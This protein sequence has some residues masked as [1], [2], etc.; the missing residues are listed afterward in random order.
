MFLQYVICKIAISELLSLLFLLVSLSQEYRGAGTTDGTFRNHQLFVCQQDCGVFVPI[1]RIKKRWPRL[2]H[3]QETL[4]KDTGYSRSWLCSE[5][6]W[7]L[8]C[9]SE[10]SF[11]HGWRGEGGACFVLW[12][13]PWCQDR[14]CGNWICKKKKNASLYFNHFRFVFVGCSLHLFF[15]KRNSQSWVRGHFG[16]KYEM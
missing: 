9:S 11:V 3:N 14:I 7:H 13:T 1:T 8:C 16:D 2:Q 15:L 5:S 4:H 10:G 6:Q 12:I